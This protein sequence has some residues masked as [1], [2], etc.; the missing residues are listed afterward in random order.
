M[1]LFPNLN[2]IFNITLFWVICFST[3]TLSWFSSHNVFFD[4]FISCF[5][6]IFNSHFPFSFPWLSLCYS[7]SVASSCHL[8]I[9]FFYSFPI[10]QSIVAIRR[11]LFLIFPWQFSFHPIVAF[12]VATSSIFS[13]NDGF[14]RPSC[15]LLDWLT[16]LYRAARECSKS[17]CSYQHFLA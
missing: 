5:T 17:F 7:F 11:P 4:S 12:L 16:S 8:R 15:G 2:L 10:F 6:F 9:P 13:A 1:V 14:D 3:I